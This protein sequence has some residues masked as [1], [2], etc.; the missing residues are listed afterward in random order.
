MASELGIGQADSRKRTFVVTLPPT[1]PKKT[2]IEQNIQKEKRSFPIVA[3]TPRTKNQLATPQQSL[4][5]PSPALSANQEEETPDVRQVACANLD[6]LKD[7]GIISMGK[8]LLDACKKGN[9]S[10]VKQLIDLGAPFIADWV[11]TSPLHFSVMNKHVEVAEMLLEAGICR[12]AKN[13]VNRTPLHI[14]ASMKLAYMVKLLLAYGADVNCKDLM[15]MTPL[16]WAA[17]K[18][19]S[20]T[21]KILIDYGADISAENIFDMTPYEVAMRNENSEVAQTIAAA[22]KLQPEMRLSKVAMLKQKIAAYRRSLKPVA[23]ILEPTDATSS[24]SP[25]LGLNSKNKGQVVMFAK[26]CTDEGGEVRGALFIDKNLKSKKAKNGTST[27]EVSKDSAINLL[28][29]HGVTMIEPDVGTVIDNAILNGHTIRLTDA[30][31]LAFKNLDQNPKKLLEPVSATG[32]AKAVFPP[33]Q[34]PSAVPKDS[35][36]S[37]EDMDS[38]PADPT[39]DPEKS[40]MYL[41]RLTKKATECRRQVAVLRKQ[42]R[43]K[44]LELMEVT[45]QI[46]LFRSLCVPKFD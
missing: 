12:D 15:N 26:Q 46:D 3:M 45:K 18:A 23:E 40:A 36:A 16:H 29:S 34:T 33:K 10:E 6:S 27:Y 41:E 39:L 37:E 21:A 11:G 1:N 35:Q 19:D 2:F 43:L 24:L 42:A 9:A 25:S 31:K 44:E 22:E 28:K 5:K 17:E 8:R 14:A 7:L 32:D 30:G 13:K 4:N 38:I 20:L